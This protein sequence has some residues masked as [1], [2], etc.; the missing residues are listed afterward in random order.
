M[1]DEFFH[2][3]AFIQSELFRGWIIISHRWWQKHKWR[4][5]QMASNSPSLSA[6]VQLLF[7]NLW[8]L[9]DDV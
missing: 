3:T 2:Y 6:L 5:P 4:T 7:S 9:G 8:L 1:G